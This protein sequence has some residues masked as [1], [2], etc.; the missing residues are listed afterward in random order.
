MDRQP[1]GAIAGPGSL[2]A[3]AQGAG[4][5]HIKALPCHMRSQQI[6][7]AGTILG[8]V[9]VRDTVK[10]PADISLCLTVA[11]NDK[12]GG[13]HSP[14]P[15]SAFVGFCSAGAEVCGF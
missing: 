11:H 2:H 6:Q 14:S 10:H 5:N 3:A 4:I 15:S 13:T 1:V 9:A 8:N 7:L 12:A